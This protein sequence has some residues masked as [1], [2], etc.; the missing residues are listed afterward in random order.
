MLAVN[1][2]SPHAAEGAAARP[3]EVPRGALEQ[4]IAQVWQEL[5][6]LERVGRDDHFFEL[7]GH[8]SMAV[9]LIPRLR[10]QFGADIGLR[11]LFQAPTLRGFA[12]AVAE[13]ASREPACA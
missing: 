3:Y 5:L 6:G 4:T 1:S 7:G 10:R 2:G 11:S 13:S 12:S 9:Q 8:S